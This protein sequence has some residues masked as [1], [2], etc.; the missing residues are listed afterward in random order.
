VATK[1]FDGIGRYKASIICD[2]VSDG[3]FFGNGDD[4]LDIFVIVQPGMD[5]DKVKNTGPSFALFVKNPP[6]E[7]TVERLY[8]LPH[9][10]VDMGFQK[11]DSD[12]SSQV[13]FRSTIR[14]IPT[15]I[16]LLVKPES[17]WYLYLL[18]VGSIAAARICDALSR[19]EQPSFMADIYSAKD[20][21]TNGSDRPLGNSSQSWPF[22]TK[23]NESQRNAVENILNVGSYG[24]PKIQLVKGPPGKVM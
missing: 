15:A 10:L 24:I 1:H 22:T 18:D 17:N 23:L 3:K 11:P 12:G 8:S 19:K 2:Y 9:V 13:Q 5:W 4:L 21:P 14:N 6:D 20:T 16:D 7:L